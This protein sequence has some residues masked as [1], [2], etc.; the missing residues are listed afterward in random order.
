MQALLIML[1]TN[2]LFITRI[3]TPI[4]QEQV[5]GTW[6]KRFMAGSKAIK[7]KA[8]FSTRWLLP[9][10]QV[11][12]GNSGPWYL[13]WENR[14]SLVMTNLAWKWW[15]VLLKKIWR[16]FK[17]PLIMD[18]YKIALIWGSNFS[19][20]SSLPPPICNTPTPRCLPLEAT[21]RKIQAS[22]PRGK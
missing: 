19:S 6:W 10:T 11:V 20:N 14:F 2:L 3:T 22:A 5:E 1:S 17:Q 21:S 7:R 8:R 12:K 16:M 4:P 9:V 18:H 13:W 15:K